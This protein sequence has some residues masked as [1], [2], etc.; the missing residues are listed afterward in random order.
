MK[1]SRLRW[2]LS[3]EPP[4]APAPPSSSAAVA[5]ESPRRTASPQPFDGRHAA[6]TVM[7]DELDEALVGREPALAPTRS[8]LV[9]LLAQGRLDLER[10]VGPGLH[11]HALGSDD[12]RVS[13]D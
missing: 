7:E 1:S 13:S 11:L 6:V 3:P 5:I 8:E 9:V 12:L 2:P 4:H 10:L